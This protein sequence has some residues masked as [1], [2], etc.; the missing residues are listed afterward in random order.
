MEKLLKELVECSTP[1]G[2]ESVGNIKEIASRYIGNAEFDSINNLVFLKGSKRE[3][4]IK[5]MISAHYDENGFI[6]SD[7]TKEGFLKVIACGGSDPKTREGSYVKV[8]SSNIDEHGNRIAYT[9]VIGK[10][11]IHLETTEDRK[12]VDTI[13]D[14]IIDIGFAKE[15]MRH[16]GV[17]IGSPVVFEKS[18]NDKFGKDGKYIVGNALDDKIGVYCITKVYDI[19]DE[20]L[21]IKANIAVYCVWCSQEEVGLRGAQKIS[22]NINPDISIDI[23]VCHDTLAFGGP[24]NQSKC[25]L[26]KGVCI[27][28]SPATN[29]KLVQEF[30]E[31]AEKYIIDYQDYASKA[32]SNNCS[33]IQLNS[34]N[35]K[36]IHLAIP[37]RNMHTQV[38]MC[39]WDDVDN[40]IS[41]MSAYITQLATN[42]Q[43]VYV[44]SK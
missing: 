33:A 41:L 5:V 14:M 18:F 10:K 1:S 23:D 4:A 39:Q 12:K 35:C 22:K 27:E 3:D 15:D 25:E 36:A 2:F 17:Y 9:G 30:R 42:E 43:K 13:E 32:G 16:I 19:L 28:H 7:I 26:G 8:I 38:E 20:E 40:C 44:S 6:V 11:A 29:E 24:K 31:I 21:L 37:N 34:E